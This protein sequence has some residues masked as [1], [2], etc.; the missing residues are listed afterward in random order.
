MYGWHRKFYE[1][2][3]NINSKKD[4]FVFN[5]LFYNQLLNNFNYQNYSK[6]KFNFLTEI[7][8]KY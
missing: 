5:Y 3:L 1:I 4:Y 8:L 7:D 6:Y 2:E